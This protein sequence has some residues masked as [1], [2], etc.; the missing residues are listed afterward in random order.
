MNTDKIGEGGA[1]GNTSRSAS[2]SMAIELDR[3]DKPIQED[4]R[5]IAERRIKRY[6]LQ[7]LARKLLPGEWV[8]RC[9]RVMYQ[10]SVDCVY[11]PRIER[12]GFRGLVACGSVWSC[13]ICAA[14]ITE[15]RRQELAGANLTGLSCVMVTLTL[16]HERGDS[17]ADLL[18]CL[19]EG[20]RLVRSG[21]GWGEFKQEYLYM[22][23]VTSTEVTFGIE[24]GWHPHKHALW[25]SRLPLDQIDT[26]SIRGWVSQRFGG[27]L[28][29]MGK[30]L[31]PI[32]GVHVRKGDSLA[33]EYIAKYGK[34]A[35]GESWGMA[36]EITK[37]SVKLAAGEHYT[38]FGLLEAYGAGVAWAG[39]LFQEYAAAMKGKRQLVYTAHTRDR[40][41]LSKVMATDQEVAEAPEDQ[42]GVI[43]AR[44]TRSQ[45]REVLRQDRRGQLE[46]V[47]GWGNA[48]YL[49][50]YLQS[51]GITLE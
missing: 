17:L 8:S 51:L 15:R 13:P 23:G 18:G 6:Y 35:G 36:H 21:R 33:G 14:K 50:I 40:L 12:G 32:H 20:Y 2:V 16:Q 3:H 24:S 7:S 43:L 41:G 28:A 5:K 19:T 10:G 38:P 31:S 47:I 25:F 46:S 30:Y 45:W 22:G 48:D 4:K 44:L 34:D 29:K 1:L 26:E 27:I 42:V 49:L 39:R 37:A 9:M 11:Y